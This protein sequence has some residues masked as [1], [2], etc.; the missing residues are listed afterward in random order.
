MQN[1]LLDS[2]VY[3]F[4]IAFTQTFTDGNFTYNPED[5]IQASVAGWLDYGY[6]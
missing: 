1:A 6:K 4:K 2:T 5:V 3:N